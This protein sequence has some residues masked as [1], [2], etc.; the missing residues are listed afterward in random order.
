MDWRLD[1]R[2]ST[3]QTL[4]LILYFKLQKRNSAD[5]SS[6]CGLGQG[7]NCFR[8]YFIRGLKWKI[9]LSQIKKLKKCVWDMLTINNEIS[10]SAITRKM[11]GW[12]GVETVEARPWSRHRVDAPLVSVLRQCGY[13]HGVRVRIWTVYSPDQNHTGS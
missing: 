4:T 6:T 2:Y 3:T 7:L 10:L 1:I 9:L 11:A 5:S 12:S 13:H 8:Y